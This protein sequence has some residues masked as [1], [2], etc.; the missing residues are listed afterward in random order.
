M[1]QEGVRVR[2]KGR[3]EGWGWVRQKERGVETTPL[4]SLLEDA[5]ACVHLS[6]KHANLTACNCSSNN[7]SASLKDTWP[8]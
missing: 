5:K 8:S 7:K 4:F 6:L 2:D 3:E 1:R